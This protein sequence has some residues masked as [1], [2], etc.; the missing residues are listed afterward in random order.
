MNSPILASLVAVLIGLANHILTPSIQVGD[1]TRGLKPREYARQLRNRIAGSRPRSKRAQLKSSANYVPAGTDTSTVTEGVD[2][3]VTFWRL[4]EVRKADDP[5]VVEPT[6]IVK[7]VKGKATEF[8]KAT[9]VRARSATHWSDGEKF[10]L[11]IEV[12]FECFVYI[13]SQEQYSDGSL[14][15]P[16]LVFPSRSDLARNARTTAGKLIYF[17]NQQDC[18]EISSLAEL[19]RKKVAEVFS[20]LLSPTT[21]EQLPPLADDAENRRVD[22]AILARLQT[23]SRARTWMFEDLGAVGT[24]ITRVE[25]KAGISGTETLTG[26]DPEPQTVYHVARTTGDLMMITVPVSIGK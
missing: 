14:S 25:K 20:I 12:P 26:S 21:L 6:R 18:F 8:N 2:I 16:Y 22:P 11:S 10:R 3:G 23:A 9:A 5:E 24:T 19:G 7:R 13:L 1:E 17:P 15:D 4:R